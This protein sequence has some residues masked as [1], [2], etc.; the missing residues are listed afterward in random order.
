MSPLTLRKWRSLGTGP[1]FVRVGRRPLYPESV[2]LRWKTAQARSA[3]L[4]SD[5]G[6]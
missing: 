4:T 1:D 5:S 3:A 2:V 6:R